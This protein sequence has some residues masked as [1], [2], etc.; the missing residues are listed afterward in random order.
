MASRNIGQEEALHVLKG[1]SARANTKL[2][3]PT[4][5][6]VGGADALGLTH[7]QP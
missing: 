1:A 2:G 6:I 5:T 7:H 4:Q 3:D